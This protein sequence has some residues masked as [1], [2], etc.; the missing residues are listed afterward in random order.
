MSEAEERAR[1]VAVA[2]TWRGTPYHH[3]ARVKGHGVDCA[4]ILAAVFEE[5]GLIEHLELGYYPPDWMLHRDAERY[6]DHILGH[7]REVGEAEA[8]I[9]DVVVFKVGRT[10]SHGAIIVDPGWP[11]AV[12]AYRPARC[13]LESDVSIGELGHRERRFFTRW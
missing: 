2:R 9:A 6:L 5:A 3:A 1:V 8:N 12:H 13:V 10:F 11:R 7:A 4:Q